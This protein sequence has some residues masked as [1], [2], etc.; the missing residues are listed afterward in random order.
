ML[1]QLQT[2]LD[3]KY[4]VFYHLAKNPNTTKV[5]E[6]LY[7]SQPA[8]SKNIRELE[9]E[10]GITLFHRERGGMRLTE[11]GQYLFT[12]TEFLIKKEREILF[13]IDR[14]RDTFKGTLNIGASTTLS[15]YILPE[16]LA[17]FTHTSSSLKINLTS[18]NTDQIE[19][20]ILSGNLHLAFIEG[21]P[22]QPDIHYIPYLRDEIVLVCA[23]HHPIAETI[24]Q[25]ELSQLSFV[26]REKGS[27]TYHIIKKQ[28][29]DAG[30][31]I[32]SLQDQLTLGT[33]EGIKQYLQCSDCFAL[34]SIYS[35]RNELSAGK[36][37]IVEIEGLK[38]ERTFYAIHRQG[39]IDPYARKFLDFSLRQKIFSSGDE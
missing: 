10:L 31:Q 19:K 36:L 14:I 25:A 37:K 23:A 15:Q 20:E 26:F 6:E 12:A 5:A 35:I 34:L 1:T 38:I 18:G 3:H 2:M 7:L 27:G 22:T 17:R 4:R 11:A 29:S 33:T 9:K 24:S 8:I 21:S 28:L 32:Q 30:I 16:I 39:E 13:E